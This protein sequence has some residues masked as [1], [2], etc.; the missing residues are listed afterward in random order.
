MTTVALVL[1]IVCG[2]AWRRWWGSTPAL[3]WPWKR[4][5]G[6]GIGYRATQAVAGAVA[7]AGLCWWA[8]SPWWLAVLTGGLAT[9][10]LAE[11][12]Q[13]L[14]IV[15]E[16]WD[17]LDWLVRLPRLPF[18]TGWTTYAEATCGALVWALVVCFI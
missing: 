12:A 10:F 5:N 6:D 15:W 7:L 14:P 4:A 2:A 1:A 11:R 8:G 9:G 3:W 17:R 13:S 18:F 16:M